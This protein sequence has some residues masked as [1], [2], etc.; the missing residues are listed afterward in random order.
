MRQVLEKN[1]T[2]KWQDELKENIRTIKQLKEYVGLSAKEEERL[3]WVIGKHPM[4]ITRYYASLIDWNDPDDP[5]KRMVVPSIDEFNVSGS[6]DTSGE[7]QNTK[8]PGLQHKYSQTAL[9][10]VTNR[11]PV[12]CRHCF[13]KRLVGLASQETLSRF[14]NAVEYV[15]KHKEI[16]NVLISGGDP[17]I[18]STS[19]LEMFLKRLSQIDHLDF[20]RIGTKVPLVLPSRILQDRRL[21]AVL[22]KYSLKNRRIYLSTQFNHPREITPQS[23]EAVNRLLSSRVIVNNQTVLLKGVNDKPR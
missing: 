16:N 10:L 15:Q 12:Y 13:R 23:T 9:I 2:V 5:L 11:C 7:F 18:L 19:V 6:Y 20:I 8:M 22:R 3:Q 1:L 14:G 21:L 4:S 17:L